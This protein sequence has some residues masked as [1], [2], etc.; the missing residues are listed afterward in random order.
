VPVDIEGMECDRRMC[1]Y[2]FVTF[3]LYRTWCVYVILKCNILG[4]S[5]TCNTLSTLL[6]L[7]FACLFPTLMKLMMMMVMV[8]Q[9]YYCSS[10]TI[11]DPRY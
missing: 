9:I 8:H 1:L 6:A 7:S 4:H 10:H 5:W 2:V 3:V 11:A